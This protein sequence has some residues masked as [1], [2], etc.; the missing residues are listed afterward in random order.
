VVDQ[1]LYHLIPDL[2]PLPLRRCIFPFPHSPLCL[3]RFL[4]MMLLQDLCMSGLFKLYAILGSEET[5][6]V[7]AGAGTG[8]MLIYGG[9]CRLLRGW[10]SAVTAS[11]QREY[12]SPMSC[13][14]MT[15]GS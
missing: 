10:H 14:L 4:F 13:L 9:A 2:P 5:A 8:L 1:C 7:M 11:R 12:I 3:S 6:G 15:P